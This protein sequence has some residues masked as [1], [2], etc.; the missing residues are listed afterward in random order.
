M[1]DAPAAILATFSDLRLVKSRK[2]AQLVFEVPM[3]KLK[4][5]LD[6]LGM[7]DP[8]GDVWCGIALV[9]KSL[10]DAPTREDGVENVSRKAILT[11]SSPKPK[12]RWHEM[13]ASQRAALLVHE[14]DMW[15]FLNLTMPSDIEPVRNEFDA[16]AELKRL[17]GITSK[18]ELISGTDALAKFTVIEGNFH[19]WRMAKQLGAA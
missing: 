15:R 8:Q 10:G 12:K 19:A 7:P 17:L 9:P 18:S 16:D 6:A 13:P 1:T 5:A 4:E 2:T 14:P 11:H 3:E